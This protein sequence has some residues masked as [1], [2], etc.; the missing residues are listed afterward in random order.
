MPLLLFYQKMQIR[1]AFFFNFLEKLWLFGMHIPEKVSSQGLDLEELGTLGF[2]GLPSLA[3]PGSSG[4]S[5][6]RLCS[7]V[8]GLGLRLP[9]APAPS[10]GLALS[11]CSDV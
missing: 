9:L 4:T 5:A 1:V 10:T 2:T 7:A 6:Y 11:T 3:H 8:G